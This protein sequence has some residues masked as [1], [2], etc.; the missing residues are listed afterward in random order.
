MDHGC[1]RQDRLSPDKHADILVFDR[2]IALST[3]RA[4]GRGDETK[5]GQVHGGKG[6]QGRRERIAGGEDRTGEMAKYNS[7]SERCCSS[8]KC[9][10]WQAY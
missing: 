9:L 2:G 6:V 7:Y 8:H 4:G 5:D 10:Q 3:G 1:V